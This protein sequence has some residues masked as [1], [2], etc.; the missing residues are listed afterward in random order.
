VA[1]GA[2]SSAGGFNPGNGGGGA[3]AG[4]AIFV[5]QGALITIDSG[6][7]GSSATGGTGGAGAGNGGADST[8]VF[9]LNG[10]VNGSATTGPIAGAL[11]S[12]VVVL[13]LTVPA[14]ATAGVAFT[15]QDTA[16]NQLNATDTSYSGTIHFTSSDGSAVLPADSTLTNGTGTFSVTLETTGNQTLTATDTSVSAITATSGAIAATLPLGNSLAGVTLSLTDSAGT[17]WPASL[18][19][20]FASTGQ[21]NFIVPSSAAAGLG[22]LTIIVSGS[23]TFTT[24]IAIAGAAPGIFTANQTGQGIYAGQIVYV[25]PDGSQTVENSAVADSAGTFA[26]NPVTLSTT[27]D[28]AYLVLYGTGLRHANKLTATLNG[29]TIPAT[30]FGAQGGF[31][32]LDQINLGPLPAS[33]AG[34][35]L[36]NIAIAVD[37]QAADTVTVAI[38]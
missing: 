17:A 35:G 31:P 28:Q 36:A 13:S 14:M 11:G 16:K 19:G 32:G 21:I 20:V 3:A 26:P 1:G 24:V 18:Y 6:A 9:N 25:H 15:V 4:P 33:L 5:Y 29:V 34:A 7:A 12:A 22:T 8:P 10:T 27:G 30:Y 2:G 38:Q 37:G 23:P